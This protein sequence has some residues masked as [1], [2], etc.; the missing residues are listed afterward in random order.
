[1]PTQSEGGG[2]R[3]GVLASRLIG[4]AIF[5]LAFSLSAVR[6][7]AAS[8]PNTVIYSGYKCATLA[9]TETT[10]FFGKA[11]QGRPPL[12]AYL[13]TFSGWLN[14]LIVIDLLLSFWRGALMVR[15]IVGVLVILCM[16]ST[17]FFFVRETLTPL[18]GHFL[19]IA[20]A[21]LIVVPDALPARRAMRA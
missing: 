12:E 2:V 11:V 3:W 9:L 14:P 5:V 17:W 1:M 18:I 15:R 21:L 10:A 19:W 20:G 8:D 6:T 16:A 7:G 4:L 13:L